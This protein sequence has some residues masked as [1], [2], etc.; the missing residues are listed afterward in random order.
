MYLSE[1]TRDQRGVRRV[2]ISEACGAMKGV[3]LPLAHGFAIG[4]THSTST[5]ENNTTTTSTGN[6][7]TSTTTT[8]EDAISLLLVLY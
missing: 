2:T 6:S 3:G 4:L 7:S 5:T 1:F 8:S